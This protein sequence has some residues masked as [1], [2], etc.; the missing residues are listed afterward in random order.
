MN[1]PNLALQGI[2]AI[3]QKA[4]TLDRYDYKKHLQKLLDDFYSDVYEEGFSDGY[5]Q[6]EGKA[7]SDA[8]WELQNARDRGE[9]SGRDGD[10]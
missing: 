3:F 4:K 5:D 6:R 7:N 10:W 9:A 8:G 2:L 1:D